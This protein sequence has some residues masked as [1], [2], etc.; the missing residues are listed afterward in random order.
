[1]WA[2]PV[3]GVEQAA[4]FAAAQ[5]LLHAIEDVGPPSGTPGAFSLEDEEGQMAVFEQS[6]GVA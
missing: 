3:G 1:M 2:L 5:D 4:A 6:C